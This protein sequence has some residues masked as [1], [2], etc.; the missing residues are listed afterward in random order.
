MV[1]GERMTADVLAA[2]SLSRSSLRR[3]LRAESIAGLPVTLLG[4]RRND[5]F[6]YG[7]LDQ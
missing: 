5:T 6:R 4:E 3:Q 1:V 7:T 2:A